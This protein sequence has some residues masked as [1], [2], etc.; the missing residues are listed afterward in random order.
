MYFEGL[1]HHLLKGLRVSELKLEAGTYQTQGFLLSS[2][3]NIKKLKTNNNE[4]LFQVVASIAG[5]TRL[6]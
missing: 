5:V 4:P 1:S 6:I 2:I 3:P